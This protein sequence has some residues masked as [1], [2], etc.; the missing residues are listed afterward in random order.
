[1]LADN[2]VSWGQRCGSRE[3]MKTRMGELIGIQT[4]Y[5]SASLNLQ[6]MNGA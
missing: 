6:G 1:M 2:P 3:D 5:R 4:L